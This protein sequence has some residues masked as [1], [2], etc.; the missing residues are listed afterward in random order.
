MITID[1]TEVP[2]RE[3]LNRERVLVVAVALADQIDIDAM[4]MR[5]LADE[6]TIATMALHK[7]VADREDL[8]DGMVEVIIRVNAPSVRNTGLKEAIRL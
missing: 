3:R 5:R 4:S 6:V 2:R 7:H 1:K 8:L